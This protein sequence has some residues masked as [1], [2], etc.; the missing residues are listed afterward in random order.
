MLAQSRKV[1]EHPFLHELL[2]QLWILPVQAEHD[3]A[4]NAAGRER[5]PAANPLSHPPQWPGEERQEARNVVKIRMK[6]EE[7]KANPAP[8]PT[9]AWA[10]EGA[11]NNHPAS[12]A[13]VVGLRME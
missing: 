2:S 5:G 7:T 12:S 1:R 9:Y 8:G 4:A 11:H 10:V 13:K 3:H 6:N